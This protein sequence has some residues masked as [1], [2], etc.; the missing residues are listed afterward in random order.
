MIL[1]TG[2]G[3]IK[4]EYMQDALSRH[5]AMHKANK[6]ATSVPFIVMTIHAACSNGSV[7]Q[8][9]AV[10]L[11]GNEVIG[12]RTQQTLSN[13]QQIEARKIPL[14]PLR[15]AYCL[16]AMDT[17]FFARF[18]KRSTPSHENDGDSIAVRPRKPAAD[19]D[20]T[21]SSDEAPQQTIARHE[22]HEKHV[23]ND[24]TIPMVRC[25]K[26]KRTQYTAG[27]GLWNRSIPEKHRS[28]QNWRHSSWKS[29]NGESQF[30]RQK[31]VDSMTGIT[32]EAHPYWACIPSSSRKKFMPASAL[33]CSTPMLQTIV[34]CLQVMK[35]TAKTL[36]SKPDPSDSRLQMTAAASERDAAEAG[37]TANTPQHDFQNAEDEIADAFGSMPTLS[38]AHTINWQAVNN[39]TPEVSSPD[40]AHTEHGRELRRRQLS[41]AKAELAL[42]EARH[43]V[44]ELEYSLC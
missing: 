3:A 37:S 4:R 10:V 40:Q 20:W 21:P 14:K 25:S 44:R 41:M 30:Q 38:A 7:L 43:K 42:L 24:R 26:S 16:A 29:I 32:G 5:A 2:L 17:G 18:R 36:E 9:A 22:Q 8:V 13:E 33:D 11:H 27:I 35:S 12:E 34:R 15:T 19:F 6:W 28:K 23:S 31:L 39:N 1:D